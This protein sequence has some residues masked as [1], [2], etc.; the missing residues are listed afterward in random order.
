MLFAATRPMRARTGFVLVTGILLLTASIAQA[1]PRIRVRGGVRIHARWWR[2]HRVYGYYRFAQ[3]PPPPP[4]SSCNCGYD[5]SGPGYG[6]GPGPE[7]NNP[8]PQP[9]AY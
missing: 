6:Y 4:P 8:P 3:P 1:R 2:P 9:A 7:Y 5:S